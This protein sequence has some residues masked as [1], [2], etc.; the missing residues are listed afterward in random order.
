MGRVD[1]RTSVSAQRS[2]FPV[3]IGWAFRFVLVE[4]NAESPDDE[5]RNTESDW[6][7]MKRVLTLA[8][9]VV[10]GVSA[11]PAI[12]L[13]HGNGHGQHQEDSSNCQPPIVIV[14]PLPPQR[15][16][17]VRDHRGQSSRSSD[18]APGG[19]TVRPS[20]T[21]IRGNGPFPGF[22]PTVRDHRV[23]NGPVV[24]DHRVSDSRPV[25]R[26]HRS[27]VGDP[28]VRDHRTP[29]VPPVVRDH[30]Q[31]T[32]SPVVR[33]HRTPTVPPVVRD[34]RQPTAAPVVRDHRV[35]DPKPVVRDHRTSN[36]HPVVRDHR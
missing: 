28:V 18:S 3:T 5:A 2:K 13:G 7:P 14:D 12:S 30:R 21:S 20:S 15:P 23:T 31:P 6:C 34:H 32:V 25:V 16:V 10:C 17:V 27:P 29:T 11:L 1:R 4:A 35:S 19:V 26:D 22:P 8:A 33:D 36:S 9:V 24:R